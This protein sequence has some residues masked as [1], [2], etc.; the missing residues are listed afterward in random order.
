MNIETC[1]IRAAAADDAESLIPMMRAL[2]VFEGY[3]DR[4][5]V[6][7]QDLV[8]RGL[9]KGSRSEFHAMVAEIEGIGLA[10]YV[11]FMVVPFTYDLR[12][13]LVLKEL[14]VD[15]RYRRW[16]LGRRLFEAV[17]GYA[18]GVEAGRIRWLVLPSNVPA[19]RLYAACGGRP[20]TAW[21]TWECTL[22]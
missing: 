7:A 8:V 14:Y 19:K 15:G 12:P 6:N 10:G 4:F 2:A 9:G 5:A 20:D 17:R 1:R 16:G 22:S 18:A 21:E 11:V 3:D 13:T